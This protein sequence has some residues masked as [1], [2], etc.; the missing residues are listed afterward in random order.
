MYRDGDSREDSVAFDLYIA[1]ATSSVTNR[2]NDSEPNLLAI[3]KVVGESDVGVVSIVK[4]KEYSVSASK[5]ALNKLGLN[6][7][8]N[9]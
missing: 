9:E 4:K 6:S 8:N 2:D 3:D 1:S 7:S 5:K